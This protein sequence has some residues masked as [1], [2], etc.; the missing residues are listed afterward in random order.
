M[1]HIEGVQQLI[2]ELVGK[3]IQLILASSAVMKN[4]EMVMEMFDFQHY[5]PIR[6]SGADLEH[7]K[8]HPEIFF[9]A[10]RLGKTSAEKCVV[11]EDSANG[12]KAAKAA[13]MKC[14]GFQNPNS[15]NQD[16]QLADL[17]VHIIG[18]LNAER[19]L[20]L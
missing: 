13:G 19:I 17:I 10:A 8:P 16:I 5:F 14:I 3:N 9:K 12:V 1:K 15:G 4:I 11:I 20:S 6:L 7:S 18:E 2:Q